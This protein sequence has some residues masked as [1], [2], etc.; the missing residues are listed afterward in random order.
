MAIVLINFVLFLTNSIT[1]LF[2]GLMYLALC[3]PFFAL[4]KNGPSK[5]QPK[6]IAFLSVDKA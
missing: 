5:Y 4:A 2:S 6:I 1:S 3:A